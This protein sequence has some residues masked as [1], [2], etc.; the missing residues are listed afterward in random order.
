MNHEEYRRVDF[1]QEVNHGRLLPWRDLIP[2]VELPRRWPVL[3]RLTPESTVFDECPG[4][5][6]PGQAGLVAHF[7]ALSPAL[8]HVLQC[9]VEDRCG[10]GPRNHIEIATPVLRWWRSSRRTT[11]SLISA[12]SGRCARVLRDLSGDDAS[13][14]M[15][16][17]G[18][19]GLSA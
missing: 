11:I 16:A 1:V 4:V 3:E 15:M 12:R 19:S 8:S 7:K 6:Q 2:R 18:G 13:I 5:R 17:L 10:D 14:P 9:A